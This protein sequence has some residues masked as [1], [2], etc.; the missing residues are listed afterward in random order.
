MAFVSSPVPVGATRPIRGRCN[1][2][3]RSLAARRSAV[4]M[5]AF[6]K[7]SPLE[8]SEGNLNLFGHVDYTS[9]NA[10]DT[11]QLVKFFVDDFNPASLFDGL[12][13]EGT[14]VCVIDTGCD[15][16]HP[17]LAGR[18]INEASANFTDDNGGS[19]TDVTD[20]SGHGT[21]CAGIIAAEERSAIMYGIAPKTRLIICKA[22]SDNGEPRGIIQNVPGRLAAAIRHGVDK[23]ADVIS[24]SLGLPDR[25]YGLPPPFED[26]YVEGMAD[27]YV[28]VQ[29]ALA[30][31]VVVCAA[32]G[33]DGQTLTTNTITPPG[34]YGGV[35]TVASHDDQGVRSSFSSFGGELD[36]M[37]PG[38]VYSCWPIG[39]EYSGR[40]GNEYESLR[41][42]S[43]ATPLV[44]GLAALFKQG[45]RVPD[46]SVLTQG[47]RQLY[48]V[49]NFRGRT[50]YE[51]RE[52][53][54]L[55]A[56]RPSEHRRDD[57]YG[58]LVRAYVYVSGEVPDT[59]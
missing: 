48:N 21:H 36:F 26:I 6:P 8:T 51:V 5:T 17:A 53:M 28:A 4:T 56:E 52:M 7:W 44:A 33:N 9:R 19:P 25:I 32:A 40:P 11:V 45:G 14:K 41:G 13:G 20:G 23:G 54:R 49:H 3:S 34:Q 30:K 10:G 46:P 24:M 12:D 27:M 29:E 16:N 18:I 39:L 15:V 37:A 31:G 43:M 42:T 55:L 50:N 38:E 1:V 58:R 47:M 22:L 59:A 35:I 57:G 2:R